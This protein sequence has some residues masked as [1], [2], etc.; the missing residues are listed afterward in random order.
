TDPR[1]AA[2][3][4][5]AAGTART[6]VNVGAGTGS[7]EDGA[8]DRSLLAV[9]PSTVMIEQRA[10]TNPVV[11]AEAEHL[12][13]PDGSFDVAMAILTVHHWADPSLGLSELRRV[14]HRQIVFG[15]DPAMHNRLWLIEEYVP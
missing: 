7:Y 6:I 11:Q 1:L 10:K 13:F 4:W 5:A 3:L 8:A 14:A 9:E 12:P 15:I 2:R